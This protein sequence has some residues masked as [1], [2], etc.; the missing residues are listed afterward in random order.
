MFDEC[1]FTSSSVETNYFPISKFFKEFYDFNQHI[2]FSDQE[3]MF[4]S[5]FTK[6]I[7]IYAVF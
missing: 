6:D 5:N 7:F 4:K 2:K 3:T 1:K